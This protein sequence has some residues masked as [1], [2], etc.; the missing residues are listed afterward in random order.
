MNIYKATLSIVYIISICIVSCTNINARQLYKK[1]KYNTHKK[2]VYT[3]SIQ[4]PQ[5]LNTTPNIR[6]YTGGDKIITEI[7]NEMKKNAFSILADKKQTTFYLLITQRQ[8]LQ[9]ELEE[10]TVKY[11]KIAQTQPYKFYRMELSKNND[12]E[13][14]TWNIYEQPIATDTGKIPDGTIIICYD[15]SY[16]D[17]IIGGS[18]I[19]LPTIVIKPDIV[20]MIGSEYKLHEASIKQLL[21]SLDLDTIHK[22]PQQDI[23]QHYQQKTILV[24][25]KLPM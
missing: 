17:T 25:N 22:N 7:D 18:S 21:A 3:G 11:L 1:S 20:Q 14:T 8:N 24:L 13:D 5:S 10:N 9:F 6:I 12:S 16:I 19:E 15:P 4:F 2:T 23:Q